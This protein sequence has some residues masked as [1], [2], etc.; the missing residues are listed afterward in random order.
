MKDIK[1]TLLVHQKSIVSLNEGH[2]N[3]ITTIVT[4]QNVKLYIP[5]N[6]TR[7]IVQWQKK[8]DV[9]PISTPLSV[10]SLLN[11]I[12]QPPSK[13]EASM[14][15]LKPDIQL[16]HLSAL[17][18]EDNIVNQMVIEGMLK[19]LGVNCVLC[20]NGQVALKRLLTDKQIF[21]IV[22]MDC[23]M[24]VMDGIELCRKLKTDIR[25]SHIPVILLTART[26]LTFKYEGIE[27]GAD[28]YVTKPFSADF[29]K[30][31]VK[32]IIEQRKHLR[33]Q[34]YKHPS[35]ILENISITSPFKNPGMFY[36]HQ[37]MVFTF[38]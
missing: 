20:E 19:K 13:N 11:A 27:T 37:M 12:R 18:A 30:V 25:T 1:R 34:I 28:D 38:S 36:L 5:A 7:A 33:S 17:V 15:S 6:Q 21:N 14:H 22:L 9:C 26:A 23:E 10:Q 4:N 16:S 32:K 31:R 35:L 8:A 3:D 29:L 2:Q 24:P